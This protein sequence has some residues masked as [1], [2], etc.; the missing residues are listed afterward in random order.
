MLI[1][2]KKIGFLSLKDRDI[3]PFITTIKL[4]SLE[5]VK[6]RPLVSIQET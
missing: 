5:E 2:K 4:T 3:S 6:G 1:K